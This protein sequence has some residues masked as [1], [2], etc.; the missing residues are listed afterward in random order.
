M[1]EMSI[2]IVKITLYRRV[3]GGGGEGEVIKFLTV[4]STHTHTHTP[5]HTPP[6]LGEIRYTEFE[7]NSAS[8]IEGVM[9]V[10]TCPSLS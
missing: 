5:H 7:R 3:G 2:K 9:K 8:T 10:R 4:L 1:K 6:D